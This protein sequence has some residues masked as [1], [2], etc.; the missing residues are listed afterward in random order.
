M[1]RFFYCHSD[2]E[3]HIN[4]GPDG[5]HL[6][7][8]D[9]RSKLIGLWSFGDLCLFWALLS[10][11]PGDTEHNV[12]AKIPRGESSESQE[13]ILEVMCL[14][15]LEKPDRESSRY[16]AWGLGC[17]N[18][19]LTHEPLTEVSG[20]AE[21]QMGPTIRPDSYQGTGGLW[22]IPCLKANREHP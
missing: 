15:C 9:V 16:Q 11:A 7:N 6:T 21:A 5:I 12:I 18:G 1:K 4:L 3:T 19:N 17:A 13:G 2:C 10:N 8:V 22:M 20:Q 14:P